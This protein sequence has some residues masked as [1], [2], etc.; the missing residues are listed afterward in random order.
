MYNIN[1]STTVLFPEDIINISLDINNKK[2][3]TGNF[4][5]SLLKQIRKEYES[6]VEELDIIFTAL[7]ETNS[8]YEDF[9]SAQIEELTTGTEE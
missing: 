1:T 7:N 9:I 5:K 8:S 3:R 2:I 6:Q 4:L